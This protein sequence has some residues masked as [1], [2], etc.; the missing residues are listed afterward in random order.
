M[1]VF[2]LGLNR[3]EANKTVRIKNEIIKNVSQC[4]IR[5]DAECFC[6]KGDFPALADVSRFAIN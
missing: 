3:V 4:Q 2:F 1:E 6:M 5:I